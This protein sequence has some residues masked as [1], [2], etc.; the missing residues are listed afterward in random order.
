MGNIIKF[1]LG[2]LPELLEPKVLPYWKK[3]QEKQSSAT[4]VMSTKRR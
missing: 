1:R 2:D 3:V 4:D